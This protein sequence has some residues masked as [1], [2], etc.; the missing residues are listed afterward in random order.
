MEMQVR[1]SLYESREADGLRS[2]GKHDRFTEAER[3]VN[4]NSKVSAEMECR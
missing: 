3:K 4:L 1:L 2:D